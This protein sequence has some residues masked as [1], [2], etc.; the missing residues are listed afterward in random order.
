MTRTIRTVDHVHGLRHG[1][2]DD[3][4]VVWEPVSMQGTRREVLEPVTEGGVSACAVNVE[5]HV[6]PTFLYAVDGQIRARFEEV[7]GARSDPRYFTGVDV[8]EVAAAAREAGLSLELEAFFELGH[9]QA[10]VALLQQALMDVVAAPSGLDDMVFA[11]RIP[12]RPNPAP[13]PRPSGEWPRWA[14]RRVRAPRP[15]E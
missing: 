6:W 5:P 14:V 11:A 4:T 12:P 10:N 9:G 13:S 7:P 2:V 8:P 1:R 3:A 15:R